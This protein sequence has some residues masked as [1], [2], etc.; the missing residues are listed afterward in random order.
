MNNLQKEYYCIKEVANKIEL[1]ERYIKEQIR[2]G[3]LPAIKAFTKW[4][5]GS[6]DLRKFLLDNS[7]HSTEV[8]SNR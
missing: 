4:Y 3:K 6:D 8:L 5:V 7:Q 2:A 1:S